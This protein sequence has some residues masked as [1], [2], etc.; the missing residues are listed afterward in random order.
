[1]K[2]S[3]SFPIRLLKNAAKQIPVIIFW[4]L[5]WEGAALLVGSSI[6]LVSP[7]AAFAR[8]FALAGTAGFWSSL[9]TSLGRIMSGFA[10]A[11]FFGITAAALSAF[12]GI[13]RRLIRPAV[14]VMNAIPIASFTIIALMAFSSANLSVFI[15]FVTVLPIIFHNTF[16]GIE[17][18]D[19]QL[20]EMAKV[21][22]APAWKRL[23]YIYAKTVAPY[24]FSAAAVG[25]GFAW[26]SGVAAEL[27]GVVRGTIGEN[28]HTARIF[29]QTADL[30]AWTIAIVLLSYVMERT[31]RLVFG[32]IIN[33][34]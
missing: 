34:D 32:R 2:T 12:S 6:V 17:N 27:I 10:L 13:F 3:S 19:P 26:K 16:K 14:N 33:G 4:L 9:G 22:G 15:A 25:I 7:R 31:F 8:L 23:V 18:T 30:F 5:V 20:L 29:L 24:V 28:L 11:L 1:M 21:F